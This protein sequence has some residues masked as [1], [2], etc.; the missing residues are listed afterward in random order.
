MTTF[1]KTIALLFAAALALSIAACAPAAPAAPAAAP[2]AAAPAA[3]APSASGEVMNL[4]VGHV[5]TEDHPYHQGLLKWAELIKER[6]EG[7]IVIEVFANSTLGNERDMIEALQL[8]ML[9]ITLPN[10]A[11]MANFTDV[12]MVFDLPYL[13]ETR[14]DA[15]AVLDSEIGQEMLDSL[16]SINLIGLAFWENGYRHVTNGTKEVRTPDDIK[17]MKIRTME[18]ETHMNSFRAWGADPT[19]M[20]WGEVYTALQQ[21]TL[22]GS[23]VP[24]A[25]IYGSKVHEVTKYVSLTGHFY[26]PA[27]LLF[28][29]AI[30]DKISAED[31][32]IIRQASIEARDIERQ[33]C[34]TA[35]AELV[36]KI[37]DEGG[38]VTEGIDKAPW[39]EMA[40]TVYD[41]FVAAHGGETLAKIQEKLA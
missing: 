37:R 34:E 11:P 22:D 12:M 19:A 33:M 2:Q 18:N 5:V 16:E 15:V 20:A 23:E 7:R 3:E 41:Q 29:K 35:D 10:S 30:W 14:E 8:G 4:K 27:P 6:T 9:D 40:Q 39:K 21:K 17:G 32:Q 26:C 1:K 25:T 36:Q 13:F 28:S 31:Q 38:V 24:L